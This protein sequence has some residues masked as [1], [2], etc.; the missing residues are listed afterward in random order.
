MEGQQKMETSGG[1]IRFFS[2]NGVNGLNGVNDRVDSHTHTGLHSLTLRGD[3]Y[4]SLPPCEGECEYHS[5]RPRVPTLNG[6][7]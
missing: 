7:F 6:L 3:D 4:G 1:M 2:L 5:Q